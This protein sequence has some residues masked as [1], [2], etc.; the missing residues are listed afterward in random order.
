VILDSATE[1]VCVIGAGPCG[2][3]AIKALRD[4]NIAC[5][6]FERN[7]DV[8]GNWYF[9]TPNSSIYRSTHLISSKRLTEYADFPMPKG[10]PPF[11]SHEQVLAYLRAYAREFGLYDNI[12]FGSAVESVLSA[13]GG[14]DVQIA[15][16]AAPRRYSRVVIANGHHWSPRTP[17]YK[18]EFTGAV[19]HSH[20]YKSPEVVHGKRVLVIGA[21]NSGCDI[22]VEAAQHASAAFISVRRGYHFLPKFMHG[23]PIDILGL[24]LQRARFPLWLRRCI[25]GILVRTVLGPPHRFGLPKPD[26]K[27]FETHPIINSQLFYQLGHGRIRAKPD[28]AEFDGGHVRFVDGTSESIDLIISA[29][30]YDVR[31]PFIDSEYLCVREGI[32]DLYLFGF[33]PQRDDLFVIGM[34]QPNGG[35]WPLAELQAKITAAFIETDLAGNGAAEKFRRRKQTVAMKL[36]GGIHF[37]ATPRHRLEVD[38]YTYRKHL[39]KLLAEFPPPRTSLRP[40][41]VQPQAVQRSAYLPEASSP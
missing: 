38:Y 19:I 40:V 32:P 12:Q 28:V 23:K 37:L 2:L 34:I 29:T 41:G 10:Y 1:R 4:R 27:L 35:L 21:G 26:H 20:D 18:G 22:A 13:Q 17:N 5:D 39:R 7:N 31:F 24:N 25:S 3:A 6:A 30:G 9:G 33:H 36:N 11:P 16:E 8:G 14:W 15:G